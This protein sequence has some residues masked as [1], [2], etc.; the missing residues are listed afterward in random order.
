MT[1]ERDQKLPPNGITVQDLAD[2]TAEVRQSVTEIVQTVIDRVDE[3]TEQIRTAAVEQVEA[4]R[5]DSANQVLQAETDHRISLLLEQIGTNEAAAKI[6]VDRKFN[7]YFMFL[8]FSFMFLLLIGAVNYFQILNPQAGQSVFILSNLVVPGPTDLCPGDSLRFGFDVDVREPGVYSLYMSSWKI[9]PEPAVIIFSELQPF[10][11]GGARY[12]PIVREW[13]VPFTYKDPADS[14]DT[15][16]L[17]GDY[18]RDISVVAVGKNTEST[19][20]QVKFTVKNTC[21]KG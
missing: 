4:V 10:V 8:V 16:I 19:P 5:T 7:K 21:P 9:S 2:Q 15:P 13:E 11:I 6:E 18:I 1:N 12:F 14:K 3:K 20:L 17:P